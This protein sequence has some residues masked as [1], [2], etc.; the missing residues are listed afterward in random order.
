[1]NPQYIQTIYGYDRWA[2]AQML[3]AGCKLTQEQFT[4]EVG[5]SFPSVRDT[6]VHIISSQW[7]WLQRWKGNSLKRHFDT[8]PFPTC[9]SVKSWLGEVENEQSKFIASLTQE[10]LLAPLSYH[11]L[12]GK[13]FAEPLWQQMSHRVNHSTYHRGQVTTM[14]RQLGGA[15]AQL[16]MIAYFRLNP[17]A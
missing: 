1:M 14:I 4:R 16:D 17:G 2:N 11:S 13:P 9:E 6:M 3:S 5:S 8:S 10:Q 7:I 15:P 12:D